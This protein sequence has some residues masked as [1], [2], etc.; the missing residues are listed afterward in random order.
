MSIHISYLAEEVDGVAP[1]VRIIVPM[2]GTP[3]AQRGSFCA[4]VDLRGVPNADVLVE[5][6]L[7]AM[8]RTYYSERGTQSQVIT[9]TVRKAQTMLVAETQRLTAP[10][11]AGVVC[12]GVMA[13]RMALAGLGSAFALLTA[14]DGAVGVFPSDRLATHATAKSSNLDLWPLHRQKTGDSTAMIAGSGPTERKSANVNVDDVTNW[15]T[16]PS[17]AT[18]IGRASH[19]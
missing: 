13:D 12:V 6:V 5:R 18:V 8:Q 3:Q 14:E 15:S 1:G 10:W 7:S 16:P 11:K 9:E 19:R 2:E 17:R 4:L